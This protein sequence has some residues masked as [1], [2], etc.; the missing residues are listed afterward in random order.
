SRR[1]AA[2]GYKNV[3][4]ATLGTGIGGGI[5]IDGELYRGTHYAGAE[6]G[7]MM[8]VHNGIP[9]N[10]GGSGCFEQYASAS[11]IVR[12][13]VNLLME[14]KK[15]IPEE[16]TSKHIFQLAAAGDIEANETIDTTLGYLGTGF[17]GLV[18]IFNPEI[19]VIGGGVADAGDEFVR[20][21][22]SAIEQRAMKPALRGL[23]VAR[24]ILGNDAGF[25][26]ALT[27]AAEMLSKKN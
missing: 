13:Y 27:L 8:I 9:C 25:V 7:H 11:A 10:C 12:L 4:C 15:P 24:A 6:I 17:A 14:R 20:R 3:I 16:V 2:K 26:G 22:K 1:G 5:L 19:I 23:V 21:I 18:N